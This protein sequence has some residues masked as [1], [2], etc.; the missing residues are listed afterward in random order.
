MRGLA[1]GSTRGLAPRPL[2]AEV[3]AFVSEVLLLET[4][5]TPERHAALVVVVQSWLTTG[6]A[7]E[8]ELGTTQATFPPV[9]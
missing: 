6:R 9:A 2:S 7:S 4:S 8:G 1:A 5:E 3:I